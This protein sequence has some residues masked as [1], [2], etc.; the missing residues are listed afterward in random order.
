[1]N[2]NELIERLEEKAWTGAPSRVD[3]TNQAPE[4]RVQPTPSQ[5]RR[6]RHA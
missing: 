6:V 2:I 4:R 3:P 5:Y 1:M